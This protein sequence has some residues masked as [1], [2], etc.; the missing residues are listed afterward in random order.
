MALDGGEN[1]LDVIRK[2]VGQAPSRL[3]PEGRVFLEIGISQSGGV[4]DVLEK[5]KFSDISVEKDYQGVERFV[6]A[7]YG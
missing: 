6:I 1:G 5:E 2:F 7:R 3:K 4:V